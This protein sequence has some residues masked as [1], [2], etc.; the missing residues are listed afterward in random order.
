MLRDIMLIASPFYFYGVILLF[1]FHIYQRRRLFFNLIFFVVLTNSMVGVTMIHMVVLN[2]IEPSWFRLHYF[3]IGLLFHIFGVTFALFYHYNQRR[4]E[5]EKLNLKYR[6]AE[7]KQREQNKMVKMLTHEFRSPLVNI[8]KLAELL[9]L[10]SD[11][12][13]SQADFI[14]KIR[15]QCDRGYDLIERFLVNAMSQPLE[16][17]AR[18]SNQQIVQLISDLLNSESIRT[19]IPPLN[20]SIEPSLT[21]VTATIDPRL[22]QAALGNMVENSIK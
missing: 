22:F 9:S 16:L 12:L 5:N 8:D 6:L 18:G 20:L 7:Q 1:A 21:G 10:T 3:D 17:R 4:L 19:A 13:S 15:S 11:N 2:W 14:N